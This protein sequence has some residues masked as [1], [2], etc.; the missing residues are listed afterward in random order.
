M[1]QPREW[2][3]AENISEDRWGNK[4][5]KGRVR[6]PTG[7]SERAAIPR[8]ITLGGYAAIDSGGV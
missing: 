4:R 6:D 3:Q 5:G 2:C 1:L 7:E 8:G